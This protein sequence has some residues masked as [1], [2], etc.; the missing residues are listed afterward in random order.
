MRNISS[1]LWLGGNVTRSDFEHGKV[2]TTMSRRRLIVHRSSSCRHTSTR[3]MDI[4]SSLWLSLTSMT[5]ALAVLAI[6]VPVS[7]R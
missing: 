2:S 4:S 5:W 1:L 7:Q 3:M 6:R